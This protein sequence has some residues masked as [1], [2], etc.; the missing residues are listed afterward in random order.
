MAVSFVK[1]LA[2]S[3]EMACSAKK[4]LPVDF[5][6]QNMAKC[7]KTGA[8][9]TTTMSATAWGTPGHSWGTPGHPWALLGHPWALLGTPWW[10]W[11]GLGISSRISRY[12][13][14]IG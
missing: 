5:L 10:V 13:I 1:G 3:V 9:T 7:L 14:N 4:S 2:K 11:G 12:W 6:A 8:R